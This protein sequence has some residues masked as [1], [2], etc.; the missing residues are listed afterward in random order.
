MSRPIFDVTGRRYQWP[1]SDHVIR[2]SSSTRVS[3]SVMRAMISIFCIIFF[4]RKT[5]IMLYQN[6]ILSRGMSLLRKRRTRRPA[7]SASGAFSIFNHQC[8]LS[9][10]RE[11]VNKLCCRIFAGLEK[12]FV[13]LHIQFHIPPESISQAYGLKTGGFLYV[14]VGKLLPQNFI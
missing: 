4:L 5:S 3:S 6:S 10:I 1:V 8:F 9:S 11:R 7:G 13:A 12:R 14:C 2:I